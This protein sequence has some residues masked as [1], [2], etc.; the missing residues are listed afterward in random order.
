MIR[1]RKRPESTLDAA[2]SREVS[3]D[4]T[5]VCVLAANA[6]TW[7][8]SPFFSHDRPHS[9]R[10]SDSCYYFRPDLGFTNGVAGLGA[11][12]GIGFRVVFSVTDLFCLVVGGAGF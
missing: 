1:L 2:L 6:L 4:R 10:V 9:H 8:I 7:L 3:D 12:F 11:G 5:F